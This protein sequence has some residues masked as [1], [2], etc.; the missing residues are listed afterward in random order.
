MPDYPI[1]K[2]LTNIT[3]F[4]RMKRRRQIEAIV[5][6]ALVASSTFVSGREIPRPKSTQLKRVTRQS[7]FDALTS[8]ISLGVKVF[9]LLLQAFNT[10]SG[11][12]TPAADTVA[13]AAS[14]TD[15]IEVAQ[16]VADP[17][18]WSNLLSMGVRVALAL[19]SGYANDGIDKSD[20]FSPTQAVLGT[21]ISALT[22]S[23]NP[24]EV[25]TM[26]KQATDVLGLVVTLV[27]AL[28]TSFL[29]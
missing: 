4:I 5:L 22:G 3:K 7:E 27:E 8:I 2:N 1:F 14:D 24:Q 17:F 16:A 29:S 11:S 18:S 20:T 21:V 12:G 28:Q 25:A 6:I 15:R 13:A 26:A 10:F 23:E 9:P 19:A